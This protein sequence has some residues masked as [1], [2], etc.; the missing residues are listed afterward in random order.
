MSQFD[1]FIKD[2]F[3]HL[4]GS[5]CKISSIRR[6]E[7]YVCIVLLYNC[8]QIQT[9]VKFIASQ[10]VSCLFLLRSFWHPLFMLE[11]VIPR[12]LIEST[13]V[14]GLPQSFMLNSFLGFLRYARHFVIHFL[15][16][17]ICAK[18]EVMA[19]SILFHCK[20]HSWRL[21][22]DGASAEFS[23]EYPWVDHAKYQHLMRSCAKMWIQLL[24]YWPL[25]SKN[26]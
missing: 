1:I 8:V 7:S 4:I 26:L 10:Y 24:L 21:V 15:R 23:S 5:S 16:I 3:K 14:R 13:H 20:Y 17:L 22:R 18:L 9:L 6:N 25:K 2:G 12:C 11:T 19:S